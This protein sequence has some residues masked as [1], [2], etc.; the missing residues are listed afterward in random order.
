METRTTTESSL[1]YKGWRIWHVSDGKLLSVTGPT[2]WVYGEALRAEVA[3]PTKIPMILMY[4]C[5]IL[6]AGAV[7]E[8]A[9]LWARDAFL[10]GNHHELLSM[11]LTS[12][13][14]AG[15]VLST[16]G[17]AIIIAMGWIVWRQGIKPNAFMSNL[18]GK[19][20]ERV[21]EGNYTPGIYAMDNKDDLDHDG[22]EHQ[23]VV[24]GAVS[25]WGE[26]IEHELGTKGEFAYPDK[27]SHI[28]CAVCREWMSISKYRNLAVLNYEIA[29]PMHRHCFQGDFPDRTGGMSRKAKKAID[30]WSPPGLEKLIQ[31]APNWFSTEVR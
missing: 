2:E 4:G 24:L 5:I 23:C 31:R 18:L 29:P 1:V 27:I 12:T 14:F 10:Q 16:V 28:L 9:S 20:E 15:Q 30:R 6:M 17:V 7:G 21:A 11:I 19:N 25:I 22:I 8:H 13:K 3:R 26:T